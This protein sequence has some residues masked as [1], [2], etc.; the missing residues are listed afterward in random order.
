MAVG[1]FTRPFTVL[2]TV[3]VSENSVPAVGEPV[4]VT[5]KLKTLSGTEDK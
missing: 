2:V 3:Q 5:V 4:W 1:E